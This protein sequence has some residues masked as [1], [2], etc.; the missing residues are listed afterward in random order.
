MQDFIR[1]IIILITAITL[2]ITGLFTHSK[3]AAKP[4]L[5]P[6]STIS[7]SIS[8]TLP[9]SLTP[10]SPPY[11]VE[12]LSSTKTSNSIQSPIIEMKVTNVSI[13][14]Y[15][16]NVGIDICIF[17][18]ESGKEYKGNLFSAESVLDKAILTGTSQNIVISNG[19]IY[20]TGYDRKL[21]GFEKCG[22]QEDGTK[23]CSYITPTLS[24][25]ECTVFITSDGKQASNRWGK[26]PI[27]VEF[28]R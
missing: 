19:S 14:P 12:V 25:K 9:V 26:N 6:T 3:P 13:K 21:D 22:Y 15:I 20:L 8:P 10:T 18:D 4:I 5:T 7:T 17:V 28:P 24:I 16:T 1:G 27:K 23:G 11:A 2:P